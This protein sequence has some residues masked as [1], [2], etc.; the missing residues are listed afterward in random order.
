MASILRINAFNAN[1]RRS[2]K[3]F[4]QINHSGKVFKEP[5]KRNSS[6]NCPLSEHENHNVVKSHLPDITLPGKSFYDIIW[7]TGIK[8][9]GN[10]IALVR[11]RSMIKPTNYHLS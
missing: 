1:C 2:I 11:I 6:L 8:E 7:E 4:F 5:R 3:T 9:H 10:K